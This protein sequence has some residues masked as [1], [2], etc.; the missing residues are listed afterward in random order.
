MR[1]M[2]VKD[3][4]K[5]RCVERSVTMNRHCLALRLASALACFGC[6]SLESA[7]YCLRAVSPNGQDQTRHVIC[8]STPSGWEGWKDDQEVFESSKKVLKDG[9]TRALF[10]MSVWFQESNCKRGLECPILVVRAQGRDSRSKSDVNAQLRDFLEEWQN[11]S[12]ECK[13]P[14]PAV[15]AFSSFDAA[16][17]GHLTIWQIHCSASNDYFVT[18]IARNDVAVTVYLR[19][20]SSRR[21]VSKLDSLKELTRSLRICD[22]KSTPPDIVIIDA[23]RLSDEAIRQ[24]LLLITRRGTPMGKVY[25]TLSWRLW[26]KESPETGTPG[27]LQWINGDLWTQIGSH[28]NSGPFMTLVTAFWKSDKQHRL[29]DVE[30]QRRRRRL[31]T[32]RP[33]PVS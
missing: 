11:Y 1:D 5:S 15:K 14:H 9:P 31:E 21:I 29:R 16:D 12:D 22:A 18:F 27:E 19:V 10:Q 13:D 28:N 3:N 26:P 4:R 33:K 24:Q 32:R 30:I 7:E 17:F 8:C 23:D 20:P 25:E 2:I 6:T